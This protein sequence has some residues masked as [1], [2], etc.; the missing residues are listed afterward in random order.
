VLD[1][2]FNRVVQAC[3]Y[4]PTCPFAHAV[5]GKGADA[6]DYLKALGVGSLAANYVL[7]KIGSAVTLSNEPETMRLVLPVLCPPRF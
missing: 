2:P 1:S 3:L 4:A 7:D 5:P 6:L